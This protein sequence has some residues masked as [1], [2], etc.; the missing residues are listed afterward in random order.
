MIFTTHEFLRV[1][2]IHLAGSLIM[3]IRFM[4]SR[5]PVTMSGQFAP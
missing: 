4:V 2:H 5:E 3:G 1:L